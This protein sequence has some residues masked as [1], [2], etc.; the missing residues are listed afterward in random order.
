MLWNA[1]GQVQSRHLHTTGI[2]FDMRDARAG[3]I[4]TYLVVV[5]G[6]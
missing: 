1:E 5:S 2:A 6:A 4:W 3:E